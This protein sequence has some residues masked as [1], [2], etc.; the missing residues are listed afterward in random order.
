MT[1]FASSNK[2]LVNFWQVAF[3]CFFIFSIAICHA[4]TGSE[5]KKDALE[6]KLSAPMTT[7]CAGVSID[8]EL[9]IKNLSQEVVKINKADLWSEYFYS[10]INPDGSG[11]TGGTTSCYNCGKDILTLYPGDSYWEAHKFPLESAF[12]R[13][14]GKYGI[15]TSI[16]SVTSNDVEFELTD[17]G[18]K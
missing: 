17:C 11:R 9:N 15:S 7:L 3:A 1:A 2:H 13:R 18:N 14:I 10:Q 12:F 6:L 16:N 8:L 4:Q 5:K